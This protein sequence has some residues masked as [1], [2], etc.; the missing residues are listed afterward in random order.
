MKSVCPLRIL[1]RLFPK[2]IDFMGQQ[3]IFSD[4][5]NYKEFDAYL[6]QNQIKRIFLVTGKSIDS[7]KIGEYF[8]TLFSR[9]GIYVVRFSSFKPNPEYESVRLGV[10]KFKDSHSD[11]IV[12][13]GGG[14]AID[15]AKSIKLYSNMEGTS[16]FL[17]QQI[18]PNMIP[19]VA[20]PT[21]AGS[22]SEATR[23]AVLY[24]NGKK[25]SIMHDSC[26]PRAVIMDS[27]SLD[28][29]P[30]R[31]RKATMMDALCHAVESYWSINSTSKSKEFSL[32]AL[33]LVLKNMDAYL[34]NDA[35]GNLN[36]LNAAHIAG[37][38]INITQTT[39]AHAMSY[40]LTSLFGIAHGIA[41]ALCMS[42]LWPYMLQHI[43]LSI[44]SRG[45]DYLQGAFKTIA[46]MFGYN[47]LE[48]S[49][50]MFREIVDSLDL[51]IPAANDEEFKILRESVNPIRLKNHPI[52]LDEKA[53]DNIYHMILKEK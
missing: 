41:V 49:S 53:I 13:V 34:N 19:L 23:F 33:N 20:V 32:E 50:T 3:L 31:E 30:L 9:L 47:S 2:I 35:L 36:M 16:S 27:S 15:V 7:L 5:D 26:I 25:Q 38:A 18:R 42:G 28:T 44:D 4:K 1:S 39:A 48:E 52:K 24:H 11:M 17:S 14:S 8:Q 12:A 22:G 37:K 6:R 10:S 29:L 21:T 43:N 46:S 40:K 51:E 45:K